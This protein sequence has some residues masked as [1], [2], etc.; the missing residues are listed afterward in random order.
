MSRPIFPV[1]YLSLRFLAPFVTIFLVRPISFR[2]RPSEQ[3]TDPALRSRL[4]AFGDAL[5]AATPPIA[6]LDRSIVID[7]RRVH[8]TL[9]VMRLEKEG[10]SAREGDRPAEEAVDEAILAVEGKA[11]GPA[12][13][14]AQADKPKKTVK[15]ALALLHSLAPQ[16]ATLGPAR[17]DLDRLGVLKP[18]KGGREANVLWV[19]PAEARGENDERKG[20]SGKSSLH[21]IADLVH[22]TFR[23][24]GYI[25]ET[26]PLKLHAT[27]LNTAHR[28]PRKRL[29]FS[30]ADVLQSEAI[31]VLGAMESGVVAGGEA[32]AGKIEA[33]AGKIEEAVEAEKAAMEVEAEEQIAAGGE[34][35]VG[36]EAVR[37]EIA[38]DSA[39]ASLISDAPPGVVIPP[40][41][42]IP[43]DPIPIA[44]GSYEVRA[45]HL[46]AM[47]SRGPNNEY[48]SL[49]CV[50]F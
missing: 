23:R 13:S 25:T 1:L 32:P 40:T 35:I 18:Q 29:A 14:P 50:Q 2:S 49:G 47:G 11:A 12:A 27:L 20:G 34:P 22:Q 30:Y 9:G 4:S 26:R 44:L 15:T 28:K 17:V 46:C 36:D 7:P 31:K 48:I 21:A 3:A 24:E 39:T 33:P 45:V 19:G 6:G 41:T 8:L 43:R 37:E 10:A 42:L 16:L 5:L 38:V